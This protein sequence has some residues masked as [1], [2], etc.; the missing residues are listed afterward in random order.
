[1]LIMCVNTA[2][3]CFWVFPEA[4]LTVLVT[5]C[6]VVRP[7]QP[8]VDVPASSSHRRA[9]AGDGFLLA[10]DHQSFGS[11]RSVQFS[12]PA[13]PRSFFP[14]Y[15]DMTWLLLL[16]LLGVLV[17]IWWLFNCIIL[18]HWLLDVRIMCNICVLPTL[19]TQKY[20]VNYISKQT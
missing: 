18:N 8:S 4:T 20:S 19:L 17:V 2:L 12:L 15:S 13:S 16:L 11:H 10:A 5:S 14:W 6:S 3:K 1:M 9:T 7:Q